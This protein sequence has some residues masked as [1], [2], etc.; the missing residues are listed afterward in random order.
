M[1]SKQERKQR[2]RRGNVA[3][4]I[5]LGLSAG[6]GFGLV[7]NSLPYAVLAGVILGGGLWFAGVGARKEVHEH[8][9]S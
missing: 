2:R 5:G 1:E 9:K 6:A 7:L 4:A 8:H 3:L